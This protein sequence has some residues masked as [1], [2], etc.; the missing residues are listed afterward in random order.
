MSTVNLE[1]RNIPD[2]FVRHRNFAGELTPRDGLVNDFAFVLV[3]RGTGHVGIRSVN[4]P[5]RYLRHRDFRIWLEGPS[6]PEDQLWRQDSTFLYEI[7][8]AVTG[9]PGWMKLGV[10]L[11]LTSSS[12]GTVESENEIDAGARPG[13]YPGLLP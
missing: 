4:F 6:S 8:M 10:R 11:P 3:G 1:S 13:G 9:R 5:D 2:H 12:L 7:F